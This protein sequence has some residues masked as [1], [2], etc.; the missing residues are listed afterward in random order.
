MNRVLVIT[1][2]AAIFFGAGCTSKEES[3]QK[4][5]NNGKVLF[6]QGDYAKARVEFLNALQ[7]DPALSESHYYLALIFEKNKSWALMYRNL[8]KAEKLDSTSVATKIKMAQLLL[9]TKNIDEMLEKTDE[10]LVLDEKNA[11]AYLLKAAAYL[12]INDLNAAKINLEKAKGLKGA[13]DKIAGVEA[14]FYKKKGDLDKAL[15][16]VDVALATTETPKPLQLL[17]IDILTQMENTPELEKT[18]RRLMSNDPDEM[19]FLYS[20]VTLLERDDRLSD[21]EKQLNHF[22]KGNPENTTVKLKAVDIVAINDPDRANALLNEYLME[23]PDN[24]TLRFALINQQLLSNKK[25]QAMGLLGE[26]AKSDDVNDATKAK[27][28]MAEQQLLDGKIESALNLVN[29]ILQ[30]DHNN[31]YGL[32]VR[33]RIYTV[34]ENT[35]LAVND[36]RVILRNN[37]DNEDALLLLG[38]AYDINGSDQLAD[39]AFRQVLD[40][41]PGSVFA[42]VPVVGRLLSHNELSRSEVFIQ[43]ALKKTPDHKGLLALMAQL[44]L[45]KQDWIGTENV[46]KQLQSIGGNQAQSEYLSGRIFFGQLQYD[47]ALTRFKKSMTLDP[48]FVRALDGIIASYIKRNQPSELLDY[49]EELKRNTPTFMP[50][51]YSMAS[52][53]IHMGNKQKALFSLEEGLT[54]NNGW[55]QGYVGLAEYYKAENNI[56]QVIASYQRGLEVLQNNN[57][58]KML[59]ATV[60]ESVAQHKEAK[61]LYESVLKENPNH[62][63]AAN[64]LASLLTDKF[65]TPQ[66]IQRALDISE[67]FKTSNQ[68]YLLD[69][70]AWTSIKSGDVRGAQTLLARV[71]EM[72]PEEAVFHYH[73][74]MAL[75]G[76][77]K[78]DASL[79]SL[80]NAQDLLGD[81][82]ED[83]ELARIIEQEMLMFKN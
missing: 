56:Q 48:Q 20:L 71:I 75:K 24:S 62:D 51:Y 6:E 18:Y 63:I 2:M 21:A 13:Y 12:S 7:I 65:E 28:I 76:L 50:L 66:N 38:N 57:K 53:Y 68:P 67:R 64:N 22:I 58:L 25:E 83:I 60:Y 54:L 59:L 61:A 29:S 42:V 23:E 5:I 37:P 44:K 34:Q 39:D 35:D 77:N 16:I 81:K 79:A 46:I 72:E 3:S 45:L 11:E 47:I 49:L 80:V 27:A 15:N 32:L 31:E 36:L 55:M 82:N 40:I 70:Y 14:G 52:V 26:I 8:I 78:L 69:T 41:N 30:R 9:Q 1:V 74:A 17:R 4:Y 19:F 43:K 73:Y 33:A 10:I